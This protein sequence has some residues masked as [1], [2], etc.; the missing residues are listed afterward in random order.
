MNHLDLEGNFPFD[1]HPLMRDAQELAFA[2]INR[3]R[4]QNVST[5]ILE[6]PVGSG[7][8]DIGY[9]YLKA[10]E[11]AGAEN[12]FYI[13][14]NKTL[15]DQV[16]KLHPDV[17]VAYGRN[18][19]LC[20]YYPEET[21]RADEIPCS[22]LRD[23]GHRVDQETGETHT[24]GFVPCPYLK[25]K[26][27]ARQ[28]TNIVVCTTAFYL[29]TVLYSK[30]F[31]VGGV[32]VD[33]AH[34]LAESL[35]SVLSTEIT[36]WKL[37]RA[38]AV[39]RGAGSAQAVPLQ[40]FLSAMTGLVLFKGAG[41]EVLLEEAEIRNLYESLLTVS[42]VGLETETARAISEGRLD[43]HEDREVLTQIEDIAR[44]VNRFQRGFKFA[45]ARPDAGTRGQH[46][47]KYIFA[48]GKKEM[49]AHERVQNKVVIK[50]YFV[51]PLVHRLLPE[52]TLAYSA[53][54]SDPETFSFETGITGGFYSIPSS[55]PTENTRIY[56]PT[57]TANLAVKAR[58]KQDKTKML[59]KIAKAAKRFANNGHR[60]LI[61]VVSQEEREKF[62]SLAK[63][64]GLQAVSYGDG[65]RPREAMN[66]FKN[67]EGDCLVGTSANYGEGIDL[68]RQT[69]PVI[70]YYRPSYPR[71]D[72]PATVF[73]ERRFGGRRWSL[74]NWRVMVNLLQARGRNIRSETDLG[75]TF[76][77]SQQFR[78]FAFGALPKW[79]QPA[80]RGQQTFDEGIEDALTL[81][82]PSL[83]EAA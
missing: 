19:H 46:P 4:S 23:C 73:E 39:L 68:P 10:L 45:L 57:D 1:R 38:I 55:F 49:G 25:Q 6:A 40:E 21:L 62:L 53:T 65:V 30:E 32:V 16:R 80:Y 37:A 77:I 79:L 74:W 11:A 51:V 27:E 44:S 75:V 13:V 72:D 2:A 18:E 58:R 64:E 78:H 33:E 61:I 63:E 71:P 69:A 54:V 52:D 7:K 82:N 81:L 31:E 76:L 50:D 56:M 34:R 29:F 22:M 28:G 60:S 26:Y 43:V 83:E 8:T 3:N 66:R 35:R 36:D 59:R 48:F 15:V 20:L 17:L 41:K 70:F 24:A 12:L 42:P 14:P 9:T 47:L 5:V 67:G